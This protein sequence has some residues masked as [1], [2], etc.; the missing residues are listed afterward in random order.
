MSRIVRY[1]FLGSWLLVAIL[2]LTWIG[3]PFAILY[4]LAQTIAI[5]HEVSD[6]EAFVRQYRAGRTG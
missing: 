1:E 5:E 2:F 4:M 6:P 3:I